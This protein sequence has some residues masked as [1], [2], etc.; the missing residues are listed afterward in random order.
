MFN[1]FYNHSILSSNYILKQ[2]YLLYN[3][4]SNSWIHLN[5]LIILLICKIHHTLYCNYLVL[6][7]IL[8]SNPKQIIHQK[9]NLV[10]TNLNLLKEPVWI[11]KPLIQEMHLQSSPHSQMSLFPNEIQQYQVRHYLLKVLLLHSGNWNIS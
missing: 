8:N 1:V 11:L 5:S 7:N 4:H 10:Y 3:I 2:G 6:T 9:Y